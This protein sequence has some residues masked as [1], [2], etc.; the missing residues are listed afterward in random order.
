VTLIILA[1]F[2]SQDVYQGLRQPCALSYTPDKKLAPVTPWCMVHMSLM[3]SH[4]VQS[5]AQWYT[6]SCGTLWT[7]QPWGFYRSKAISLTMT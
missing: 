7:G 6:F 5:I 1:K 2:T 4:L 3:G